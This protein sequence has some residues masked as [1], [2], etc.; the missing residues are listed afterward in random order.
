MIDLPWLYFVSHPF[1][2]PKLS[3]GLL[4]LVL[5]KIIPELLRR[6]VDF[7]LRPRPGSF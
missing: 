4:E 1:F 3:G 7:T 5:L 2:L 6:V